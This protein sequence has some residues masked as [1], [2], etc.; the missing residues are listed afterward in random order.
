MLFF[1]FFLYI[2]ILYTMDSTSGCL[3]TPT[4]SDTCS[5][6]GE[7]GGESEDEEDEEDTEIT[8]FSLLVDK[9]LSIHQARDKAVRYVLLVLGD[10]FNASGVYIVTDFVYVS[11]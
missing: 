7:G 9:L 6:S 10:Y 5:E 2:C 11:W 4:G 1:A 3:S 8:F